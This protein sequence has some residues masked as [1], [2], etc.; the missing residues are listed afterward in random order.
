MNLASWLYM[1][2]PMN[3][4][5]RTDYIQYV[6]CPTYRVSRSLAKGL[7]EHLFRVICP[8]SQGNLFYGVL[9]QGCVLRSSEAASVPPLRSS[10]CII[11]IK[12]NPSVLEQR[13]RSYCMLPYINKSKC[14][15]QCSIL[16]PQ[17]NLRDGRLC[18]SASTRTSEFTDPANWV[19]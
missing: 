10:I 11:S 7:D 4:I 12:N 18:L 13:A 3:Q 5:N 1:I 8:F 6:N 16:E 15:G 14:C 2:S 9:F 17:T 19:H